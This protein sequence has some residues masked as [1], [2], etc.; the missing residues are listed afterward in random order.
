MG[1]ML[2]G[3][4]SEELYWQMEWLSQQHNITQQ[5]RY[6]QQPSILQQQYLE[7]RQ[8]FLGISNSF[9]CLYI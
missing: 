8:N 7:A 6:L 3:I 4:I 1:Y 9:R 5:A 2:E